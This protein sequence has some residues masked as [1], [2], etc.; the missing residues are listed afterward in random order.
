MHLLHVMAVGSQ[1]VSGPVVWG[2]QAQRGAA[3]WVR[4]RH[5]VVEGIP[6]RR[7]ET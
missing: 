2:V 4:Q 3:L 7:V 1:A 6:V 5:S